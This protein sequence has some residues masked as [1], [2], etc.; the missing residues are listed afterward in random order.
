MGMFMAVVGMIT[1]SWAVE[2][3]K[4]TAAKMA[5]TKAKEPS[6]REEDVSLLKTGADLEYGKSD[7][8]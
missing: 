1:Y 8:E 3:A 5:I 6:F 7:K 4:A 2:V